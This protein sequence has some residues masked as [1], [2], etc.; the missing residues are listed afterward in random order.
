MGL[1]FTCKYVMTLL[2]VACV[3]RK[4][5]KEREPK[6][7]KTN[8]MKGNDDGGQRKMKQRSPDQ[9]EEESKMG[10]GESGVLEGVLLSV[11]RASG[12]AKTQID[13]HK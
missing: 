2:L 1:W 11:F 9:P 5:Y 10:G 12:R 3:S 8:E 4:K 6:P 13:A 7:E